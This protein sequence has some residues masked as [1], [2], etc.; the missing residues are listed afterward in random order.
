MRLLESLRLFPKD[1]SARQQG[2]I[3]RFFG[4]QFQNLGAQRLGRF[5]KARVSRSKST[6]FSGLS[7]RRTNTVDQRIGKAR[8]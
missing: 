1:V 7:K 5:V 3:V 4:H 6:R 8:R 2:G